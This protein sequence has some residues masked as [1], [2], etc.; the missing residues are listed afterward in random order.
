MEHTFSINRCAFDE[1]K[2]NF[3]NL[4]MGQFSSWFRW[5]EERE[6]EKSTYYAIARTE[7]EKEIMSTYTTNMHDSEQRLLNWK[8]AKYEWGN[9]LYEF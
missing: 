8:W 5:N 3:Y 1:F 9:L 4:Q 6:K 2:L 7:E